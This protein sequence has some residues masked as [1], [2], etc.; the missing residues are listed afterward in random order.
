VKASDADS[1]KLDQEA[2]FKLREK[3]LKRKKA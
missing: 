3:E 1:D 2:W